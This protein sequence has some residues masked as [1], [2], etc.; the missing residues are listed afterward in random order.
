MVNVRTVISFCLIS[1]LAFIKYS[2]R[3]C[4]SLSLSLCL[5]VCVCVCICAC[6]LV[7]VCTIISFCISYLAFINYSARACVCVSLS[8]CV[9]LLLVNWCELLFV[10]DLF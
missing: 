4:V 1:Y 2:A 9:S 10:N 3:V 7:N 5:C 8:L 6:E